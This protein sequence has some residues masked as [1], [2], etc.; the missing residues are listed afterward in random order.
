MPNNT[1]Q[2]ATT[3][4]LST[5]A[6]AVSDLAAEV[7]RLREIVERGRMFA[8]PVTDA[9]PARMDPEA[10]IEAALR[11]APAAA[12]DLAAL[13]G[14]SL[15]EVQAILARHVASGAVSEV[16]TPGD[17]R[18]AWRVGD[19][20]SPRELRAMVREL[21]ML[22]PITTRELAALT[23]A[24]ASRVSGAVVEIQR[25]GARVYNLS[26]SHVHR[27]FLL[28]DDA[29]DARLNPKPPKSSRTTRAGAVVH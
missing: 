9:A 13:S 28:P 7:A 27:W 6:G 4:H 21:M 26:R 23:G 22:R 5:S 1:S 14:L 10:S 17:P 18:W 25:S 11:A 19:E 29:Q 15:E 20:S 3:S 16:G 12:G 2:H 24:R 8:R